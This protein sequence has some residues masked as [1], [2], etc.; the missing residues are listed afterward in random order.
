MK[1]ALAH[2]PEQV[3]YTIELLKYADLISLVEGGD[4]LVVKA[5]AILNKVD[6]H[7]IQSNQ[8]TPREINDTSVA[9]QILEKCGITAQVTEYICQIIIDH[10]RDENIDTQESK[11]LWDAACLIK[12]AEQFPNTDKDKM[13]EL[14]NSTFKTDKGKK[15]A[16]ELFINQKK[17]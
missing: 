11:V 5:S 1:E 8:G 17:E 13:N 10:H 7:K 3:E 15:I 12:L 14:I 2:N 6:S 4:L 16:A 9:K